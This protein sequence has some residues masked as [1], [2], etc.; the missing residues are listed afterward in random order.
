M[1]KGEL[2]ISIKNIEI[3]KYKDGYYEMTLHDKNAH[4]YI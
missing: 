3:R 4:F 2:G 1:I